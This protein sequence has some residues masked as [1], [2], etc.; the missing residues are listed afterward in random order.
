[1]CEQN[2]RHKRQTCQQKGYSNS[3]NLDHYKDKQVFQQK[4]VSQNKK[5]NMQNF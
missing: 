1:M 4:I 2:N 5:K 3:T